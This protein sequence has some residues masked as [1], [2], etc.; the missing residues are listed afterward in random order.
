MQML[1]KEGERGGEGKKKLPF[2]D[3]HIQ[4]NTYKHI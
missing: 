4:K 2:V 1:K 3:V